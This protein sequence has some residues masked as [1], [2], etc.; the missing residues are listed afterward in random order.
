MILHQFCEFFA[1]YNIVPNL[2]TCS[3]HLPT[4][5]HTSMPGGWVPGGSPYDEILNLAQESGIA[6]A[7]GVVLDPAKPRP[8]LRLNGQQLGFL[9]KLLS[10]KVKI[11]PTQPGLPT[12]EMSP[13]DLLDRVTNDPS[14][15]KKFKGS[16]CL[17]G[18]AAR[19]LLN[20]YFMQHIWSSQLS[21]R[22]LTGVIR[23]HSERLPDYDFAAHTAMGSP[24]ELLKVQ[25]IFL[26]ILR[27]FYPEEKKITR[28]VVKDEVCR[29]LATSWNENQM[30]IGKVGNDEKQIELKFYDRMQR[31]CLFTIDAW[32]VKLGG[33]LAGEKGGPELQCQLPPE[34]FWQCALDLPARIIRA[35]EPETINQYGWPRMMMLITKEYRCLQLSLEKILWKNMSGVVPSCNLPLHLKRCLERPF[36]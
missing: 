22:S 12:I 27:S 19:V 7:E 26:S 2:H 35:P 11:Q 13:R 14:L 9:S 25:E 33:L 15:Q 23:H 18:G 8:S 21:R 1:V 36:S 16:V 24:E 32:R 29:L 3:G 20:P 34:Y 30:L 4:P 28:A 31:A 17:R 6:D 10:K 5:V